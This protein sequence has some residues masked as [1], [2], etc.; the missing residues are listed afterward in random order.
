DILNIL[1]KI[2]DRKI[3]YSVED[4][5]VIISPRAVEP[6]PLHTRYF[7]V[8]PNTFQQG[9]ANVVAFSFGESSQGGGGGGGGRGGGG[10]GGGGRG[11]GGRGNQGGNFGGNQG[12][13]GQGQGGGATY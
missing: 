2:A 4:F 7:H 5:G 6:T 13:Q 1:E 3:K 10:R 8:D 9:L 12:G 11:G